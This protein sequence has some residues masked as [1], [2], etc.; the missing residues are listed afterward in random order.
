MPGRCRSQR[1]TRMA[2][3]AGTCSGARSRPWLSRVRITGSYPYTWE[4]SLT[5]LTV[6]PNHQPGTAEDFRHLLVIGLVDE[7]AP[8]DLPV[9]G[10]MIVSCVA[11]IPQSLGSLRGVW[12]DTVASL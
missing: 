7:N 2:H 11:P 6:V 1:T 5:W 10:A 3:G 12:S 4:K 8:V 9:S